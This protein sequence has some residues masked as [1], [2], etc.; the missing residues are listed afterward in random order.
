VKLQHHHFAIVLFL[1]LA[2]TRIAEIDGARRG[3]GDQVIVTV[4]EIKGM[5]PPRTL[6]MPD[7]EADDDEEL[8]EEDDEG[9][10]S[11]GD[12]LEPPKSELPL[13]LLSLLS[14]RPL[15]AS[16]SMLELLLLWPSSS[17]FLSLSLSACPFPT[18]PT[19]FHALLLNG[20]FAMSTLS[21]E[22]VFSMER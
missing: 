3:P 13:P 17:S 8:T 1:L 11:T 7:E 9:D 20:V 19:F 5:D 4:A 6:F 21:R 16:F 15:V 18:A 14:K 10:T 12:G 2:V 22:R